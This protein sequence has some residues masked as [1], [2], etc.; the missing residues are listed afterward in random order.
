MAFEATSTGFPVLRKTTLYQEGETPSSFQMRP[1]AVDRSLPTA[2]SQVRHSLKA[3]IA[4]CA[5]VNLTDCLQS[6]QSHSAS[7]T[8]KLGP[9]PRLTPK[10]RRNLHISLLRQR[11]LSFSPS[12]EHK[13]VVG[14]SDT[15]ASVL[16]RS[17]RER[18]AMQGHLHRG[19]TRSSGRKD[20]ASPAQPI[21]TV[22][23]GV[24]LSPK[25]RPRTS[26]RICNGM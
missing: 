1:S 22:G 12:P 18:G 23:K 25:I 17:S 7:A 16:S 19:L 2:S 21:R 11:Q 14:L 24:D 4:L 15:A 5:L 9:T 26:V 13:R 10:Q 8:R 6:F 3:G 20:V